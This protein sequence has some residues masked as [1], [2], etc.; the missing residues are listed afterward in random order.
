MLNATVRAS[1]IGAAVVAVVATAVVVYREIEHKG[2][3]KVLTHQAD[4]VAAVKD[5]AFKA[6][7]A[8]LAERLRID[9]A[10][11][12][13]TRARELR[14]RSLHAKLDSTARAL[15]AAVD[16]AKA[17]L[18]DSLATNARL[19]VNLTQVIA[20]SDSSERAHRAVEAS[21][22]ADTTALHALL[23][24]RD[25]TVHA[26]TQ[27]LQAA[28]DFIAATI[29]QRDLA[30]EQVPGVVAKYGGWATATVL[31]VM[32]ALKK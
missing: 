24:R 22:I 10:D 15:S 7:Q 4:S 2:A 14:D 29:R 18:A 1:L 21:L 19:R 11:A 3:L 20:A 6:R 28:N 5:S 12:E 30:R 25:V 23:R 13:A 26:G 32:L 27:A 9:S 16:S 17:A 31:A 8:T